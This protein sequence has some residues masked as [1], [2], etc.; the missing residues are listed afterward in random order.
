LI[1]PTVAWPPAGF[2]DLLG[3]RRTCYPRCR[4]SGERRAPE[5][6]VE[7]NREIA[8]V[9]MESV[10]RAA[11]RAFGDG[12]LHTTVVGRPEGF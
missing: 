11:H 3:P 4:R 7:R 2:F 8:G 12:S 5:W 9:T 6:L 10:K 1:R